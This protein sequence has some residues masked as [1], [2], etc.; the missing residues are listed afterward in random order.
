M[1][2]DYRCKT[3]V[4]FPWMDELTRNPHIGDAV[5][6]ILG[7]N[8]HCWD[9]LFWI[10]YPETDKLVSWHQDATY[11]NF[12]PK[13]KALTVWLCFSGATEDMGCIRYIPGSHKQGQSHHSDI[14][15]PENL[16][17]RGQTIEYPD[18]LGSSVPA[19]VPAGHFLMH[20]PHIVHGS[21]N[22]RTKS[23]RIACGMVFVSTQAKPIATYS[24]ESS[25]MIRGVDHYNHVL[26]DLAPTG[27]FKQDELRWKAAYDR[28][29]DNYY[30]MTQEA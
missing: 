10:K 30:K 7:S 18:P 27:N 14:H 26:H 4:L 15:T 6:A 8:F 28:Q 24:P 19:E 29:H 17:M 2:S 3:N 9:T 25:I 12:A 21:L 1:Q 5:E 23:A 20:H 11:W 22:N 16:L 13:E